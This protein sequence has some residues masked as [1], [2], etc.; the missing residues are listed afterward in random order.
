MDDLPLCRLL[1]DPI[2]RRLVF[3]YRKLSDTTHNTGIWYL[4]YQEF[5]S[6]GVRVTFADHGPLADAITIAG[7]DGSRRVASIDSRSGNGQVYIE[8]TQDADDSNLLTSAGVVRFR[9][10][11]KEF[12]PA[13]P[14]GAVTLGT[15]TWMHDTGPA[16]IDHRFYFDRRDD[17][18]EIKE[19]PDTQKRTA[20]EVILNRSVNSFSLEIQSAGTTSYGVHWIDV[21]GLD[22]ESLGGRKGA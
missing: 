18:P 4:D 15:A 3:I 22:L 20:S 10:R 21:E 19:M 6:R 14:R 1:D 17:N 12:M 7:S 8:S 9:M 5:Q 16:R 11:T 2:N 13:G